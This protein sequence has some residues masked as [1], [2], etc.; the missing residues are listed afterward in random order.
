MHALVARLRVRAL[1][2]AALLADPEIA[3][4]D[5]ELDSLLNVNT[6]EDYDAARRRPRSA[7]R[8]ARPAGCRARS[9]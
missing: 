3:A 7:G 6:R 2:E 4:L 1:D 5:P 8:R 9:P